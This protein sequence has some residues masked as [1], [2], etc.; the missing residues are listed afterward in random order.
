MN[1][2]IEALQILIKYQIKNKNFRIHCEHED[3]SVYIDDIANTKQNSLHRTI[4][5]AS[6]TGG[7]ISGNM[8]VGGVL[9]LSNSGLKF[10]DNA[11]GGGGDIAKMY[12]ATKG[13]EATTMTFEVGNDGDDTINFITPSSTGLTHNSNIILDSINYSNYAL[14]LH[15]TADSATVASKLNIPITTSIDNSDNSFSFLS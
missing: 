3:L 12:L 8:F 13:G 2:L 7:D 4:W 9:Q 5:G 1:N 14:P 10:A 11:F 15:G 6:D